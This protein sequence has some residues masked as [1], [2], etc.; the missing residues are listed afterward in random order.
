VPSDING[1][2]IA[3]HCSI[4]CHLSCVAY[5]LSSDTHISIP[6]SKRG[7]SVH[8]CQRDNRKH[9]HCGLWGY[10]VIVLE[11]RNL[12]VK[13]Y[14]K[15]SD[16]MGVASVKRSVDCKPIELRAVMGT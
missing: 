11:G 12:N 15:M 5:L 4:F 7:S 8:R 1:I 16:F 9:L 6:R 14:V 13:L 3:S 10:D 2:C